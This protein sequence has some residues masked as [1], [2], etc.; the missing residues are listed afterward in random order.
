MLAEVPEHIIEFI[1]NNDSFLIIGH[2]EPDADCLGSQTAAASFLGRLGK[3]TALVSPGPF[4][5][6]ETKKIETLFCRTLKEAVGKPEI[7]GT[8]PVCLI[9]DCS[10]ADRIG[11]TLAEEVSTYPFA[12]IDH[13][14]TGRPFG[15]PSWVDGSSPSTTL[16]LYRLMKALGLTPEG[17]EAEDMFFGFLTD[18][19]YFRHLDAGSSDYLMLAAE[20]AGYGA[21]PK[22]LY[23]RMYGGRELNSRI[24]TGRILSRARPLF[25]GKCIMI[26]ETLEEKKQFGPQNRD[27]DTIYSQLLTVKDCR[28]V[29]FIR[30]EKEDECSVSL[31][32]LDELDVGRIAGDFGGGGHKRAAGFVWNGTREEIS[33][34]L[35]SVF[36]GFL[37]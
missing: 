4:I 30:E 21:S 5:R 34:K 16:L 23:Y 7:S 25:G 37:E 17:D 26:Y 19:G 15:D 22:D 2:E 8:K 3:N 20:L 28:A 10:T 33:E 14:A 24:L 9:L 36:R 32:S 31:R 1:K 35:E 11:R 13:H 29:I 27:S 6:P 12:V 18:T